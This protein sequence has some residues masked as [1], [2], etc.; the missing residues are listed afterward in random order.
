MGHFC[1]FFSGFFFEN[2]EKFSGANPADRA[3]TSARNPIARGAP[4]LHSTPW[5][6]QAPVWGANWP[7]PQ[8]P[9]RFILWASTAAHWGLSRLFRV[10]L[11]NIAFLP[12]RFATSYYIVVSPRPNSAL[13]STIWRY[14]ELICFGGKRL[15]LVYNF[16]LLISVFFL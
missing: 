14:L 9:V 12:A 4:F 15:P 10:L 1:T 8:A 7:V 3:A 2:F 16:L 13:K 5:A 6:P 11:R